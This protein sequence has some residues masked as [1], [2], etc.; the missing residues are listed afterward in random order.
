MLFASW[1][2][3][4]RHSGPVRDRFFFFFHRSSVYSDRGVFALPHDNHGE[5]SRPRPGWRCAV[6]EHLGTSSSPS[7]LT[8]R[9]SYELKSC[10]ST[11][12]R[13]CFKSFRFLFSLLYH[14]FS[15][16]SLSLTLPLSISLSH[17]LPTL[18]PEIDHNSVVDTVQAGVQ[19][20]H[21]QQHQYHRPEHSRR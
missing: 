18:K 19:A 7:A 3:P 1:S 8:S 6:T 21:A 4:R 16:F 14:S 9:L 2:F 13:E 15:S 5:P 17:F 20:E 10:W 11:L 12:D